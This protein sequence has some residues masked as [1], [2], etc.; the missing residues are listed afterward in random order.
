VQ[1]EPQTIAASLSREQVENI[2]RRSYQYVAMFNVNQKFALDSASAA[3]FMKR[4]QQTG[5]HDDACGSHGEV[6]CAPQ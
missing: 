6:H 3:M 5:S 1:S 2:V 4:L